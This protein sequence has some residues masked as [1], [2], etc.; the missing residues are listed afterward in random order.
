[1]FDCEDLLPTGNAHG[2]KKP[3][4]ATGLVARGD[5]LDVVR[6]AAGIDRN[7]TDSTGA[8]QP[9]RAQPRNPERLRRWRT[10]RFTLRSAPAHPRASRGARGARRKSRR[11]T[12]RSSGRV[13]NVFVKRAQEHR[14]DGCLRDS[15]GAASMTC[16]VAAVIIHTASHHPATN[17]R[18]PDVMRPPGRD[19]S[20]SRAPRGSVEPCVRPLHVTKNSTACRKGHSDDQMY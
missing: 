19:S 13:A 4:R 6:A 3:C 17:A 16:Q 20:P 12:S 7:T 1:V 5:D 11:T 10:R 8:R 14:D 15:R 2:R 9:A 18:A